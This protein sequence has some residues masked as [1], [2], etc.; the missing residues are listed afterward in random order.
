MRGFMDGHTQ[1]MSDDEDDHEEFS[2][3]ATDGNEEEGQQDNDDEEEVTAHCDGDQPHGEQ[4]V[5]DADTNTPLNS[6]VRDPHVQELLLN[7]STSDDPRV[8]GR[9]KSKLA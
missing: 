8:A 7:N 3:G 1:W 4:H 6:V 5:E 9:Q 2:G